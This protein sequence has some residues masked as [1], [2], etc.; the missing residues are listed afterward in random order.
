MP[1]SEATGALP[2]ST[3]TVETETIKETTTTTMTSGTEMVNVT[4]MKITEIIPWQ[5]ALL[6]SSPSIHNSSPI[7]SS[8][9]GQNQASDSSTTPT[10]VQ[11][12]VPQTLSHTSSKSSQLVSGRPGM[13]TNRNAPKTGAFA[14]TP[15]KSSCMPKHCPAQPIH[16]NDIELPTTPV[17]KFYMVIAGQEL[18]IFYDCQSMLTASSSHSIPLEESASDMEYWKDMIDLSEEMSNINLV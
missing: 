14:M 18:G 15:T 10:H 9:S 16:P 6:L 5:S 2:H 7:H 11:A 8:V 17:N 1:L 12:V 4:V 3:K 13:P